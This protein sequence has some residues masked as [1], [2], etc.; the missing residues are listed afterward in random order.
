MRD[1]V[2]AR[3]PAP[4]VT[5]VTPAAVGDDQPLGAGEAV[6]AEVLAAH[7]QVVAVAVD[8]DPG[9][10]GARLQR[11]PSPWAGASAWR[12]RL[13]GVDRRACGRAPPLRV[14]GSARRRASRRTGRE[15]RAH[16]RGECISGGLRFGHGAARLRRR[17]GAGRRAAA[18]GRDGGA[19]RLR[20]AREAHPDG[21]LVAS[22]AP[23]SARLTA[24]VTPPPATRSPD[25]APARPSSWR[26]R[27]PPTASRSRRS[28][29]R[30]PGSC[31]SAPSSASCSGTWRCGR[32]RRAGTSSAA[33]GLAIA[34][35]C[36]ATSA[37]RSSASRWSRRF[38]ARLI[39]NTVVAFCGRRN[40]DN[41]RGVAEAA[42]TDS[43]GLSASAQLA[44][45]S[46]SDLRVPD[47]YCTLPP[48]ASSGRHA[49]AATRIPSPLR[50]AVLR[51][52]QRCGDPRAEDCGRARATH[53]AGGSCRQRRDT[54]R[55]RA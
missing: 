38:L 24:D 10:R 25:A 42:L 13:A 12:E 52:C 27:R 23:S 1:G 22:T 20:G 30:W 26:R 45:T 2:R 5:V 44:W 6:A 14:A 19:A 55:P 37:S 4:S 34:G 17:P 43:A 46:P 53:L 51:A 15:R 32:S 29:A 47:G 9:P 3:T 7:D 11:R 49:V 41:R 36:W 48:E 28:S 16:D 39:R 35:S 40:V 33:R 50:C 54:P 21:V 18:H 31:G 8:R